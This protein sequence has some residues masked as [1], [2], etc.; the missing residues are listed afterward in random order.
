[1]RKFNERSTTQAISTASFP[2]LQLPRQRVEEVGAAAHTP[3]RDPS[4]STLKPPA[5]Q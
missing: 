5:R 4:Y 2:K 1:L 3:G